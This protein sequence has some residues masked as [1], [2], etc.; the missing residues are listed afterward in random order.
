MILSRLCQALTPGKDVS[1]A[2]RLIAIAKISRFA[3]TAQKPVARMNRNPN[4]PATGSSR[5]SPLL[6]SAASTSG[7]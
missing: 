3:G 2:G 7:R 4:S 6:I 1:K 5:R